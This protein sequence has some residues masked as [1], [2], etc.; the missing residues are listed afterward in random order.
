MNK[1]CNVIVVGG[2]PA[3]IATTLALLSAGFK[4][5]MIEQSDYN[6]IRVGEHLLPAAK[7]LLTQLGVPREVWDRVCLHC[8]EVQ[9]AWGTS[10]LMYNESIWNPY[11]GG[12]ILNRSY[13]DS[14]LADYAMQCGAV[15]YKNTAFITCSRKENGWTCEL[16]RDDEVFHLKADFLIDATGRSAKVVKSLGYK[17]EEYDKLICVAGFC[18]PLQPHYP[19]EQ[20]VLLE[21]CKDGWWYSI[22]LFD[23]RIVA[24][25]MTDIDILT[26]SRKQPLEFWIERLHESQYTCSRL[27]AY[28]TASEVHV[29]PSQSHKL[30]NVYGDGWLAVGDAAMS[31]D[32][33]SSAG[34]LKG[35][36]M[37][38]NAAQALELHLNNDSGSLARYDEQAKE[39]Y[40]TYLKKRAYYYRFVTRWPKSKFWTRRHSHLSDDTPIYLDPMTAISLSENVILPGDYSLLNNVI[41]NIDVEMIFKLASPAKPS[42]QL[43]SLYKKQSNCQQ[44]DREIILTMQFLIESGYLEISNQGNQYPEAINLR[45]LF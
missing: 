17:P 23:G 9:S 16:K 28:E 37:G 43:V 24:T 21:A 44:L 40:C 8:A 13:F 18:K 41:P 19:V 20:C 38:I 3:G 7:L 39:D 42:H 45:T 5:I 31:C 22:R 33:L 26:D 6:E 12:L 1:V 14:K 36:K 27:N 4:V 29:R 34:I 11:G 32:P 35:L 2:G 30:E 25:Y 10:K 15:V